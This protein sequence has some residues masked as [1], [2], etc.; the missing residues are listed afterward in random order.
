MEKIAS[1]LIYNIFVTEIF[2]FRNEHKK[3]FLTRTFVVDPVGWRQTNIFLSLA[4]FTAQKMKFSIEDY[5]S[6]SDQIGSFLW[7]WLHLL[8]EILN[9]KLHFLC[10]DCKILTH[11]NGNLNEV[12]SQVEPRE[13]VVRECSIRKVFLKILKFI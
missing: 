11:P 9:G 1:I 12:F 5:F 4:L 13:T 7:I 10:S 2:F 3:I 8:P 6:K